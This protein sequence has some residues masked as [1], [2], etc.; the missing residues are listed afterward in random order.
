MHLVPFD[1][2]AIVIEDWHVLQHD[3]NAVHD[4]DRTGVHDGLGLVLRTIDEL[5][6]YALAKEYAIS[7]YIAVH[8]WTW[9]SAQQTSDE[10]TQSGECD[11]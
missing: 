2:S 8:L 5:R 9:W 4:G 7:I 10:R 6:L 11:G 1:V 3:A